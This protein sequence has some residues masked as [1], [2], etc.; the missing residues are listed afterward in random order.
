MWSV[1]YESYVWYLF[2]NWWMGWSFVWSLLRI[3]CVMSSY[4]TGGWVGL[5]LCLKFSLKYS[6]TIIFEICLELFSLNKKYKF[7]F[8]EKK[9]LGPRG[10]AL[11]PFIRYQVILLCLCN[12][13][14]KV[15]RRIEHLKQN[16]FHFSV[17]NIVPNEMVTFVYVLCLLGYQCVNR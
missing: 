7:I 8:K 3:I 4:Q 17:L 10:L 12:F 14:D 1:C 16:N 9:G 6:T 2:L 13:F 11:R 15:S 5:E